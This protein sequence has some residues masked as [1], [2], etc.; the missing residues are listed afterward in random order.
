[1]SRNLGPWIVGAGLILVVVGLIAWAGGLSWIGR[2]P[3]DFRVEG[4]RTRIY[5]PLASGLVISIVLT[6]L[7]NV[8]IRLF[9]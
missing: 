8:V 7:V 1:M 5:A 2:L 9:R 4:E 3:G 6:V